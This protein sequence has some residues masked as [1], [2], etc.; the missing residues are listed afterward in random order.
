MQYLGDPPPVVFAQRREPV[1]IE[2]RQKVV[3]VE[4]R[5]GCEGLYLPRAVFLRSS[6]IGLGNGRLEINDVDCMVAFLPPLNRKMIGI[7][8]LALG[9]QRS[10]Q[11]VKELPQVGPRL[12]F[13]G[14]RPQHK[15]QPLPR[16]RRIAMQNQICDQ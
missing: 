11:M 2:S 16:L 4:L 10:L 7:E 6:G 12:R 9:R 8:Y 14:G 5:R 15:G 13:A 1:V 3:F